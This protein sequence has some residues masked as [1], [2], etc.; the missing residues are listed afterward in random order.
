MHDLTKAEQFNLVE[1]AVK[2]GIAPGIEKTFLGWCHHSTAHKLPLLARES[3]NREA[4]EEAV[5]PYLQTAWLRYLLAGDQSG[6]DHSDSATNSL[7]A[8]FLF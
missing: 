4:D 5:F 7:A 2:T 6:P 1:D 3:G 8:P